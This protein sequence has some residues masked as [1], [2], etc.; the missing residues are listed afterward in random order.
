MQFYSEAALQLIYR[1]VN[2]DNPTLPVPVSKDTVALFGTVKAANSQ[3]RNST[4]TVVGIPGKGYYGKSVLY[5]DRVQLPYMFFSTLRPLIYLPKT[6]TKVSDALPYINEALGLTLTVEDLASPNVVI[7]PTATKTDVSIGI[8]S[9]SAGFLGPLHFSYQLERGTYY[10]WSG[11][12]PKY[13]LLGDENFGYFGKVDTTEMFTN[14][15]LWNLTFAGKGTTA[16]RQ[17]FVEGW[18]KFFYKGSVIF[19]PQGPVANNMSWNDLYNLGFMYGIDGVGKYPTATPVSQYKQL[20]LKKAG[21]TNY[22]KIRT[23]RASLTEPDGYF[24]GRPGQG[25]YAGSELD[26]LVH[27]YSGG[28]WGSENGSQWGQWCIMQD[29][30]SNNTATNFRISTMT[31]A[32]WSVGTKSGSGTGWYWWPVLEL[33]DLNN[34]VVPLESVNAK[35]ENTLITLPA[36]SS[37]TETLS[38]VTLGVPKTVLFTPIVATPAESFVLSP[39]AL[40]IPKTVD[41]KPI[42]AT[43]V[44]RAIQKTDLSSADG[45]LDG[46]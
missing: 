10:G 15:E 29:T 28:Q 37:V 2:R 3:G 30:I 7:T 23:P 40:G 16:T 27:L 13:L 33:L 22:F 6:V 4:V 38:P 12:G 43:A 19:M 32:N 20:T 44:N 39:V 35:L 26:L 45:E 18:F 41:Y 25:N 36:V 34:T 1:Q 42:A 8:A 11:P 9:T 17:L 14:L 5:F 21:K 46:F 31:G 24:V